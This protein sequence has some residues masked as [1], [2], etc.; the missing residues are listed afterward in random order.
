MGAVWY[1]A[2]TRLRSERGSLAAIVLLVGLSGGTVMASV[3]AARRTA[4]AFDRMVD[5]NQISP[6]TVT[7]DRG[8]DSKL[9]MDELRSL[10]SVR[11]A[12]RVDFA[13]EMPP[14]PITSADQ[15]VNAP[16]LVIPHDG[17]GYGTNRYRLDAGRMPQPSK[18]DELLVE[19]WYADAHHLHVGS[20]I[21]LTGLNRADAATLEGARDASDP[22]TVVNTLGTP[23][24]FT[25]VGIGGSAGSVAINQGFEPDPFI[26]T[27]AY[28]ERFGAPTTGRWTAFVELRPGSTV[29]QFRR[30]VQGLHSDEAFPVQSLDATHTQVDRAVRPQVVALWIFAIVA[31]LVGLLVIGQAVARRLAADGTDNPTLD[32]IGMA[33]R[34]RFA[35]SMALVAIVGI[36]GGV[37]A[38]LVSVALSPIAP[39]GPARLAEPALGVAADWWV[40]GFGAA[41]VAIATC[42][43]GV[44]PARR[45]SRVFRSVDE[46][47]PSRLASSLVAA[48]VSVPAM[49]GV[50]FA[51]EPGSR[52]RPIP[53]RSTIASASTAVGVIVAV[54]TFAT[55]LQ[56]LVDTPRLFGFPGRYLIEVGGATSEVDRPVTEAALETA[57]RRIRGVRGFSWVHV[58]ELEVDE[59][60]IPTIAFRPGARPVAPVVKEGRVPINDREVALGASTMR[61]LQLA[62]GDSV[63]LGEKEATAI[64]V[65]VAVLPAV[66]TTDT[67]D[68][69]GLG[70]GMLTTLHALSVYGPSFDTSTHAVAV[71]TAPDMTLTALRRRIDAIDVPGQAAFITSSVPQPADI[72]ALRRLRSTPLVL[73]GLLAVLIGASVVHALLLALRR[74]RRDVAVLQCMGLRPA[75]VVRASLWQATTIAL[76]AAAVGIPLGVVAGRW[77]WLV[78]ADLLGVFQ[79]PVVPVMLIVL[80]AVGVLVTANLVGLVPGWRLARRHPAV[81]LRAE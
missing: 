12:G 46:P 34:D 76:I 51:L 38:V 60:T 73:A 53:A 63:R 41:G 32:A 61:R 29:D 5:A 15:V 72:A 14:R 68:K 25:V 81:A 2:R 35:A 7:P 69:S 58:S 64:V 55:S 21:D 44:W 18:P 40:L 67:A 26:A 66:A 54:V 70:E 16:E 36:A 37:V 19:R 20:E 23:F 24:R 48:G 77:S 74:R 11:H 52:A 10:P 43:I 39:I 56:H 27:R 17:I 31:S 22:F 50:R 8:T 33:R 79:E 9:T 13:P 42:A 6:A 71:E 80:V 4:S 75:Q 45:A 62:L 47:R 49:T 28:W 57:L 78:L 59:H 3:A 30:E 65:G 1:P